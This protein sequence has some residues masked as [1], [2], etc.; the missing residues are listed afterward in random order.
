MQESDSRRADPQTSATTVNTS[1][2]WF[3]TTHWS[4]VVT[5][6]EESTQGREALSRLCQTYWYPLYSFVRRSGYRQEDAQD[7]T[8]EFFARLLS[9]DYLKAADPEKGKF[10]SFLLIVLKRFMAN[11][12]DKA[13]RQKRGGGKQIISLDEQDT[14]N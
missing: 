12:W 7:L 10:R 14:E 8:Q 6:G 4:A 2:G 1:N 13:Q 9:H 3:D 11:E 5:A